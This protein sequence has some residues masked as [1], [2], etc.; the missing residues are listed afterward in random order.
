M[1]KAK[2]PK[3]KEEDEQAAF[4]TKDAIVKIQL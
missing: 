1:E 3:K 4:H 2:T